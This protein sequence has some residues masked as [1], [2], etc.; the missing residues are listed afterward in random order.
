MMESV[1]ISQ[2]E[3]DTLVQNNSSKK[4]TTVRYTQSSKKKHLK[5]IQSFKKETE[6]QIKCQNVRLTQKEVDAVL[7]L[8]K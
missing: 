6:T 7:S 2:E 1:S 5:K 8:K 4:N 3:L